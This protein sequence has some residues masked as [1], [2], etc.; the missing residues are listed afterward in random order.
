[1]NQWDWLLPK[2]KMSFNINSNLSNTFGSI[3][4]PKY[5]ESFTPTLCIHFVD[6]L[7]IKYYIFLND[8]CRK[9]IRGIKRKVFF[10]NLLCSESVSNRLNFET[11]L[12]V[13][14]ASELLLFSLADGSE[15]P[16]LVETSTDKEV[17]LTSDTIVSDFSTTL[18]SIIDRILIQ[19]FISIKGLQAVRMLLE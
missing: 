4:A 1:M 5:S 14:L 12:D 6:W 9:W 17:V 19:T 3:S 16:S 15:E 8:R 10:T 11:L 2:N 13:E 7:F 18:L